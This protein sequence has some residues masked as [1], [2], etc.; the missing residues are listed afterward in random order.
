MIIYK[1]LKDKYELYYPE[2]CEVIREYK[3]RYQI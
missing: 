3:K 2:E 1:I